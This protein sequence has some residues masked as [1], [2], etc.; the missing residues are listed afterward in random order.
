MKA[1]TNKIFL[2]DADSFLGRGEGCLIV[3]DRKG[4]VEKYRCLK[5]KCMK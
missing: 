2:D 4:E 1:K 3:R 5:M